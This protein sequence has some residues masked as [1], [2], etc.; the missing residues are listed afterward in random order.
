MRLAFPV[1]I[2]QVSAIIVGFADNI[3][4]GHYSTQALA[5][6]SFV[7]NIFNVVLLCSMGFSYGLTPLI[8][9]LF[10]RGEHANIGLTLRTGVIANVAVGIVLTLIMGTLYF[11]L[12][13]MGQEEELL[14]LQHHQHLRQLHAHLRQFRRSGTWIERCW[15]VHFVCARPRPAGYPCSVFHI[16]IIQG[17]QNR[18][19]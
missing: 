18:I 9:M 12:D 16:E 14:T 3:M 4:V 11:F 1:L 6:S 13:H 7:V 19:Y 10:S 8:G 5:A 2:A 17:I 15:I